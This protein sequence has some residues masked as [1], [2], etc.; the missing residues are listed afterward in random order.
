VI[1]N[2]KKDG[3]DVIK[4]INSSIAF[5][6]S[7]NLLAASCVEI[8]PFKIAKLKLKAKKENKIVLSLSTDFC[9]STKSKN[10]IENVVALALGLDMNCPINEITTSCQK[11]RKIL[12]YSNA[13]NTL[14]TLINSR[15]EKLKVEATISHDSGKSCFAGEV[16][17]YS[18]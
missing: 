9:S 5:D 6:D 3:N 18:I 1:K 4:V 15:K 17:I 14:F 7:C 12:P 2:C 13:I 10:E 8:K 16:M 11:L